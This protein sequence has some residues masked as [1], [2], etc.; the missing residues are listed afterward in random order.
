MILSVNEENQTAHI[1]LVD[2]IEEVT[3]KFRDIFFYPITMTEYW[4][5]CIEVGLVGIKPGRTL[6]ET[7][8]VRLMNENLK[9]QMVYVDIISKSEPM[10]VKLY[11]DITKSTL[12]YEELIND[13]I[14]KT[15]KHV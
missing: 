3:V 10:K 11:R 14:Y 7:D 2:I 13:N 12:A 5:Q 4:L 8:I 1:N 6:R 9:D 15:T